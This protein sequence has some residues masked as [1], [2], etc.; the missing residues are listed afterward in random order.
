MASFRLTTINGP[1]T[2]TVKYD[3]I[4]KLTLLSQMIFKKRQKNR[5]CRSISESCERYLLEGP[6][7]SLG[8][9]FGLI[10]G[11]LNER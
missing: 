8:A 6:E 4:L 9:F 1:K 10:N 5:V 3:R 7:L 2:S 11:K